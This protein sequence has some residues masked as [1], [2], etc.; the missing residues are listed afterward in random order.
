MPDSLAITAYAKLNL[1]LSVG[2]PVPPRGYHPIAS[3]FVC[4]GLS[5]TLRLTR[6]Q[7]GSPSRHTIRWAPG[8]PRPTPIDWPVERD[9]A[10]RAHRLLE[11]HTGRPL[12]VDM[13]VDK[14]IP[15][16]AGLGGGSSDAAAALR[17]LNTLFSLGLP[18]DQLRALASHLGSD[19]PFFIDEDPDPPPPPPPPNAPHPPPPDDPKPRPFS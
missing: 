10:V 8:A 5:D 18:A 17:A 4:I 9:L 11:H 6:L 19:I 15:V 13:T 3:W 12:P 1:A 7:P 14:R 2:P 16:G